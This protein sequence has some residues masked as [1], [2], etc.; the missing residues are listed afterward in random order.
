MA[1]AYLGARPGEIEVEGLLAPALEL[2][3]S[4]MAFEIPG[5]V[6]A[7]VLALLL[8]TQAT[9]PQLGAITTMPPAERATIVEHLVAVFNRVLDARR[10]VQVTPYYELAYLANLY[11][12][13]AV[14]LVGHAREITGFSA[15]RL[16]RI[17][18]LAFTVEER[19]AHKLRFDV[20][21]VA[22]DRLPA[23]LAETAERDGISLRAACRKLAVHPALQEVVLGQAAGT[24]S[25]G[26]T[27]ADFQKA[28]ASY[29]AL[30][31]LDAVDHSFSPIAPAIHERVLADLGSP[32]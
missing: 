11:A 1:R 15:E 31:V 7:E 28:A 6:A 16:A 30:A 8:S 17:E 32:S 25:K 18:D 4:Y 27:V 2:V 26:Q 14:L 5:K 23:H 3:R 24:L 21:L 13:T 10:R 12:M 19:R 29:D 9:L 22:I 20:A